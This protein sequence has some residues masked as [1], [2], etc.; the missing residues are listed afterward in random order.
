MSTEESVGGDIHAEHALLTRALGRD[1][2]A[3]HALV[4]YLEPRLLLRANALLSYDRTTGSREDAMDLVQSAWRELIRDDWRVLRQWD[5]N[6]SVRLVT[7]VGVVA[8][9]KMITELRRRT[10]TDKSE[11]IMPPEALSQ[12]ADL[13]DAL[14]QRISDRQYLEVL[15][16][17]LRASLTGKGGRAFEVLY[18]EDL[19]VEEA[20][21]RTNLTRASLYS[22][23]RRIKQ[24]VQVIAEQLERP[25]KAA[26]E[27]VES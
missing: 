20:M 5:P 1:R 18:L 25:R 27:R 10:R 7:Y 9:N 8:S 12:L 13:T 6:R 14:T 3:V 23:R 11:D 24:L 22:Y 19:S 21:A 4:R 26:K 16:T 15:L 2:R 17:E